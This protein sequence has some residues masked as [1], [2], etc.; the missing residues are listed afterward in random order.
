MCVIREPNTKTALPR[1]HLLLVRSWEINNKSPLH[2]TMN[3]LNEDNED[4]STRVHKFV[5]SI[6]AYGTKHKFLA[7]SYLCPDND[8]ETAAL[9]GFLGT[10]ILRCNIQIELARRWYHPNP[11]LINQ[12]VSWICNA[13]HIATKMMQSFILPTEIVQEMNAMD[14]RNN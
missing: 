14:H 10:Y 5:R 1:F 11:G 9:H 12:E 8:G 4:T 6:V 13:K 2:Q 3:N 7:G